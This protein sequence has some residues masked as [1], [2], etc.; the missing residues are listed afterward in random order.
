MTCMTPA[1]PVPEHIDRIERWEAFVSA[2]NKRGVS[3]FFA[4]LKDPMD[5]ERPGT[6]AGIRTVVE[7]SRISRGGRQYEMFFD[8]Q[9][10]SGCSSD[11]ALCERDDL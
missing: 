1:R 10:G 7:W 6:Y 8:S 5:A 3:T 4:A 9:E 11:L 2:A